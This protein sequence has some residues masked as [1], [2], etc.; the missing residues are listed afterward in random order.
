MKKMLILLFIAGVLFAQKVDIKRDTTY[1]KKTIIINENIIPSKNHSGQIGLTGQVFLKAFIDTLTTILKNSGWVG[2][3]TGDTIN[4]TVIIGIGSMA[5]AE[6]LSYGGTY[7]PGTSYL[8]SNAKDTFTILYGD[9][10]TIEKLYASNKVGGDLRI[11]DIIGSGYYGIFC[12]VDSFAVVG[13]AKKYGIYGYGDLKYGGYFTAPSAPLYAGFGNYSPL[14]DTVA[15][16][17][18]EHIST[19]HGTNA[20]AYIDSLG[21]YNIVGGGV[22]SGNLN[23]NSITTDTITCDSI[24]ANIIYTTWLKGPFWSNELFTPTNTTDTVVVSGLTQDDGVLL[25]W[26][27]LTLPNNALTYRV[28][29]DTLF[30]YCSESDTI[31]A[32]TEGY[33]YAILK[34]QGA[35]EGG[36]P[37]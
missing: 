33:T 11:I 6:S 9:T 2:S 12:L 25:T 7:L 34:S 21:G 35:P 27:G 8:R 19:V 26:K 1:F 31:K 14:S 37:E 17:A 22:F 20:K 15:I 10:I 13:D 4:A 32:R 23:A 28:T 36:G 18:G 16:F 3:L 29:T 30:V 24:N 5:K